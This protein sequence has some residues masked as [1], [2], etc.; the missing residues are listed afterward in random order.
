MPLLSVPCP[1]CVACCQCHHHTP[2]QPH[3]PPQSSFSSQSQWLLFYF[4]LHLLITH[5]SCYD[6]TSYVTP[7]ASLLQC[8]FTSPQFAT[9][10]YHPSQLQCRTSAPVTTVAVVL[11]A[12]LYVTG[13]Y[14]VQFLITCHSCFHFISYS[15]GVVTAVFTAPQVTT[16][17]WPQKPQCCMSTTIITILFQSFFCNWFTFRQFVHLTTLHHCH[18]HGS[19]H[20]TRHRNKCHIICLMLRRSSL[21]Q[22]TSPQLLTP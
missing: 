7:L 17:H 13:L 3:Y 15:T 14:V 21:Q 9:I 20:H 16:M 12:S 19:S 8:S 22:S 6:F 2:L 10:H 11:F 1:Q 5:H 4:I 18:S